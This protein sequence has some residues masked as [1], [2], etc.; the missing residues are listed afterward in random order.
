[1]PDKISYPAKISLSALIFL[2]AAFGLIFWLIAPAVKDTRAIKIQM[3]SQSLELEKNYAQGKNLK[4]LA[5]NLKAVEPRWGEV[6]QIFIKNDDDDALAFFTLLE[7]AEGKNNVAEIEPYS[8]GGEI[9]LGQFYSQRALDL[10][11]RGNFTGLIGFISGLEP[12][13]NYIN[14]NSLQITALNSDLLSKAGTSTP[15]KLLT[16]QISADTYWIK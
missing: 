2:L 5:D 4:K 11:L 3:E 10:N 7:T 15:Q 9:P 6:E 1:M 8:L 14:I 13:K 16:A 12:L